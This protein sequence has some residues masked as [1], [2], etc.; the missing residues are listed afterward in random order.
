LEEVF[1]KIARRIEDLFLRLGIRNLSMDDLAREL[2]ISKKTLYQFVSNKDELVLKVLERHIGERC[3]LSA[4]I[5]A[6][7]AD[8]LDELLRVME[9]QAVD[10]GRIKTNILFELQRYH[11][12]AWAV[13]ERYHWSHLFEM[14]LEN[15]MWGI[16]DGIYRSDFKPQVV[17]RVHIS[18][19]FSVMDDRLFPRPEYDSKQVFR[20]YMLHYLH[21]ILSE[22]GRRLL[23]ERTYSLID[24]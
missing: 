19:M 9:H 10:L 20:E 11:P 5:R 13:L 14:V 1:E 22:R 24:K 21:G 3:R 7:S 16:R 4:G 15:L 6:T 12:E 17:A 18:S 2:G 8:A 23:L